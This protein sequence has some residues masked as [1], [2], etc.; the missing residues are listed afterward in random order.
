MG[1]SAD[2]NPARAFP[3]VEV[4]CARLD[5]RRGRDALL[6]RAFNIRCRKGYSRSL[7]LMSRAQKE[8]QEHYARR[9]GDH[10]P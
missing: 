1:E 10:H 5:I 2:E 7:R 9:V 3:L 6:D 4:D 8:S